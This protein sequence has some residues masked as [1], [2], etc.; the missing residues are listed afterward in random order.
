MATTDSHPVT[1]LEQLA[2]GEYRDK[3][4]AVEPGGIEP[5]PDADKH[6]RPLQ[7]LWTWASPNLEFATVFV[8]V[9]AVFAFGLTFWQAVAALVLGNL[10]GSLTHA[11]LSARGPLFG[12]PQM[13]LS[14]LGFGYWGNLL[15]AG[16][17]A[18]MAGIG[19]FA[20]NSVSGAFALG[21]LT[22]LPVLLCLIVIVVVQLAVAFFGHNLVHAFERYV[23]PLLAVVFAV[24]TV[25]VLTKAQPAAATG[26]GG[27]GGFLLTASAAFGYAAGWNPY[28]ADYTRYLPATVSRRAAGVFA[29]L[30]V[31][32]S[33]TVLEIAGAASVTAGADYTSNPTTAFTGEL[34]PVL[35]HLTLLC[36]ALGAVAANAIN[37]YSGSLS[38]LSLNIRLSL[39]WRRAIVAL[40][41]GSIGFVLAWTGLDDAGHAYENFLLIIAYWVA[42]WLAVVLLDQLLY[43][44][45]DDAPLLA[46]PS[47]RNW[48]GPIAMLVGMVVSVALFSNQQL[49]TGPVPKAVPEVGD[50]APVVGFVL[51][52]VLYLALRPLRP[53][54][55]RSG[56]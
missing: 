56:G 2:P 44:G 33:C 38:F 40:G 24:A 11:V 8:G 15:P 41:F 45:R 53:R 43:R 29:G 25:I 13:V 3:I 39:A 36:I 1:P 54:L 49:Y 18:I 51:A 27:I 42:P 9:L 22:H 23:L 35:S 52:G 28:A 5:I 50:L 19:W 12:V 55:A 34:P 14:R 21:S 47:F 4:I 6:G 48:A 30:G 10:L 16:I 26:G 37:I 7:L 20:V 32:I 31:F 46:D 17:N